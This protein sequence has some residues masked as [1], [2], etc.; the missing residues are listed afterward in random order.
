MAPVPI[1]V[2]REQPFSRRIERLG[3][4]RPESRV[5]A[6]EREGYPLLGPG[7]HVVDGDL[8]WVFWEMCPSGH[9]GRAFA[10]RHPELA[11]GPD[12]RRWGAAECLRALSEHGGD[13][14][15]NLVIGEGSRSE[16]E[17]LSSGHEDL[18]EV[19]H[20]QGELQADVGGSSLGGDRPKV[21]TARYLFKYSPPLSTD[22][23][24]RWGDL[25]RTEAHCAAVLR[26]HGILA[27]EAQIVVVND[28]AY[29]RVDRY[30][31]IA[32]R[33]RRGATTLY[34]YAMDRLGDV[35]VSAPGVVRTLIADG[36]L[37]E[38]AFDTCARIH[39]FS[40]AIGN[41]DAH[42]GNYGLTFD[43]QGRASLAPAFDVLPMVLAPRND[44]LPDAYVRPRQSAI[45]ERALPLVEDLASR[46]A[47]DPHVSAGFKSLWRGYVGL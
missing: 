25:L 22:L 7:E 28:R 23:G 16:A 34:F 1:Y 20:A 32:G 21:A 30:D 6:L 18:L 24:A 29:L 14:A 9:L 42:L 5:I 3:E 41:T 35:S 19:L 33:G 15:G 27:T 38:S 36:H 47:A 37:P 44:E 11:L 46:I 31:R 40:L 13:L 17:A 4:W 10:R 45:P 26:A 8:P 2:V 12:P 43:E 39:E